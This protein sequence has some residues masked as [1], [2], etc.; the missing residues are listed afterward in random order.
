M[1]PVAM[2]RSLAR[3]IAIVTL[4]DTLKAKATRSKK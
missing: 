1:F 4:Y 2:P 3:V